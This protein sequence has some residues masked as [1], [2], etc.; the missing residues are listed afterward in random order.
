MAPA[1]NSIMSAIPAI[2]SGVGSAMN[3]TT[4]ELG[5]ALGIAVLGT[6]MNNTYINGV[7]SIQTAFRGCRRN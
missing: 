7:Q 3:D 6:F 4:R 5:A 2:K 1:T